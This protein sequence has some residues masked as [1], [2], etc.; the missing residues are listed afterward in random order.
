MSDLDLHCPSEPS[1]TGAYQLEWQAHD[2]AELQLLEDGALI[3]HGDDP[4]LAVSGRLAG[5]HHYELVVSD[6]REAASCTV[7]VEPPSLGV[8][9]LFFFTGAVVFGATVALIAVGHRRNE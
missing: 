7:E 6:T 9:A 8:A 1:R 5:A 4:S 3:Y 2:G